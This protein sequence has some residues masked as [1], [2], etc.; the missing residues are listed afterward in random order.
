MIH[1]HVDI[2]R[3]LEKICPKKTVPLNSK[4]KMI[5]RQ[6]SADRASLR[7]CP[8][9]RGGAAS[10]RSRTKRRGDNAARSS[11]IKISG[12]NS[13]VHTVPI[14]LGRP[15]ATEAVVQIQMTSR[16]IPTIFQNPLRP[17]TFCQSVNRVSNSSVETNFPPDLAEG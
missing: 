1:A 5:K 15:K 10:G 12:T 17:A 2:F 11:Q 4:L 13:I 14:Q 8:I 6:F 16:L 3:S 7:A 9:D